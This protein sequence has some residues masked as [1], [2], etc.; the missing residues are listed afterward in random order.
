VS[1][2]P[3]PATSPVDAVIHS[4][5]AAPVE[6]GWDHPAEALIDAMLGDHPEREMADADLVHL[7]S[8]RV[9]AGFVRALAR[10]RPGFGTLSVAIHHA[11]AAPNVETREAAI[12]AAEESGDRWLGMIIRSHAQI[13]GVDWLAAHAH[14]VADAIEIG[15]LETSSPHEESTTRSK[16]DERSE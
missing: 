12:D 11:L 15:G 1:S 9:L 7:L 5:R 3:G 13:E 10:C 4:I 16:H 6:P 8:S 14:N 2:P